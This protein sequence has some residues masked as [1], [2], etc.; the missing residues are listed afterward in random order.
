MNLLTETVK[1]LQAGGKSPAA[2]RWVG[3]RDGTY[4]M[5][6]ES[7]AELAKDTTYHRFS[8]NEL[9]ARD[10]VIV[11]DI[12]WMERIDVGGVQSWD[13]KQY[14]R[15]RGRGMHFDRLLATKSNSVPTVRRLN[16]KLHPDEESDLEA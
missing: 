8:G 5:S 12:W 15:R 14:P 4:A 6:W 7:F 10:L 16:P 3:S 11:G 13:V 9:V 1:A 2:V